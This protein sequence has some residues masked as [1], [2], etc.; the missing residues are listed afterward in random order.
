MNGKK[1]KYDS[2]RELSMVEHG[3]SYVYYQEIGRFSLYWNDKPKHGEAPDEIRCKFC[4][5]ENCDG[6]CEQ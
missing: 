3:D 4:G 1:M 2:D 5:E 6:D